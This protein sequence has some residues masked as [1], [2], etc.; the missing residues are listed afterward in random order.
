MN[1]P[2]APGAGGAVDPMMLV[3]P[4]FREVA[5]RLAAQAADAPP[6]TAASIPQIRR[7]MPITD[8]VPLADVDH[9]MRRL[10]GRAG[11]PDV[12]VHAIN[13]R[14]GDRRPAILHTHGG[15]HIAGSAADEIRR[16]QLLARQLDCVIVTI[17]YRLSPEVTFEASTEDNYAGLRWLHTHADE[18][19]VD[20]ARIA[21][22]GES[23]GGTHAALLAAMALDR[24]EYPIAFQCLI[25]PMLDDRT[26]TT[27]PAP[28]HI[29]CYAW[30]PEEN[31]L[32]WACFLGTAP[33]GEAV[34][35]A[36]VPSRRRDLRGLPPAF[37]GTGAIDL[38]V[39]EN[40]AYASRLIE[41]GVATELLVIP[42]GYHGFDIFVPDC[43]A[44]RRFE[45]AKLDA[46]RRGLGIAR[47]E[48]EPR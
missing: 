48:P 6:R 12:P 22:L 36:A 17:D 27:R 38:F 34:P 47:R 30:T 2:N 11:D 9:F 33:G 44:S 26:G 37:I 46:L 42:G 24:G 16:M 7:A 15:G 10:P 28:P 31:R 35:S 19:G 1:S 8:T 20:T 32:G 23:A 29:G 45:R 3:A 41:A 25:Y 5:A 18:L 21:L 39:L 4:E 13:A 40:I 14:A 43:A